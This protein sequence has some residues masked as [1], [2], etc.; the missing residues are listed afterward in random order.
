MA[1]ALDR[2]LTPDWLLRRA[3]E[4]ATGA[5]RLTIG[6]S[7]IATN[8]QP[9][10]GFIRTHNRGNKVSHEGTPYFPLL[11]AGFA[12]EPRCRFAGA[13][14]GR[15]H[16]LG[17]KRQ[18]RATP[19]LPLCCHHPPD[20]RISTG[21]AT[22][23][24]VQA[25]DTCGASCCARRRKRR[26]ARDRN[27]RRYVT[28][29]QRQWLHRRRARPACPDTSRGPAG[30]AGAGARPAPCLPRIFATSSKSAGDTIQRRGG[31][32]RRERPARSIRDCLRRSGACGRCSRARMQGVGD[33]ARRRAARASQHRADLIFP[34]SSLSIGRDRRL[35]ESHANSR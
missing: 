22:A 26:L 15:S 3:T 34:L 4:A 7:S 33:L 19:A 23:P 5:P 28:P 14:D 21:R 18:P 24:V 30:D 31:F 35:A 6:A 9:R 8:E 20:Q 17:A 13:P 2:R 29:E 12:L 11:Q 10:G 1:P 16:A 25:T 27:V 32:R